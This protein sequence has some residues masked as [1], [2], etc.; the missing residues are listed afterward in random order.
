MGC[1]SLLLSLV[2]SALVHCSRHLPVPVETDR[3]STTP[4]AIE[5]T[6]CGQRPGC[7]LENSLR[8]GTASDGRDLILATVRLPALVARRCWPE[9]T[10]LLASAQGEVKRT[11]L[12]AEVCGAQGE[13]LPTLEP[14]GGNRV[15]YTRAV[16][17]RDDRDRIDPQEMRDVYDLAL[18]PPA[19]LRT[20]FR[21]QPTPYILYEEHWDHVGFRGETCVPNPTL[22]SGSCVLRALMLPVVVVQDIVHDGRRFG[23]DGWKDTDLGD[24]AMRIDGSP[25]GGFVTPAGNA[26]ASV[27]A[28]ASGT[29]VYLQITDDAFVTRGPVAD[30]IDID[31]PVERDTLTDLTEV[32]HLS[33]AGVLARRQGPTGRDAQSRVEVAAPDAH[34]R[35]FRLRD[36]LPP[37]SRK[38]R[39]A[40]IDVDPADGGQPVPQRLS[41]S[42]EG[43]RITATI[44]RIGPDDAVCVRRDNVLQVERRR[45]PLDPGE[46]MIPQ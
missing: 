18:D 19:I 33:M 3:Q 45:R 26:T 27:R 2:V 31:I 4:A 8:T 44:Q 16:E 13:A 9:E 22:D 42:E 23:D 28:V 10:W 37:D 6:A 11:Q 43:S 29:D 35:R 36:V 25:S 32:L 41:S 12:I 7:H 34:T 39:I 46:R 1:R 38:I 21:R 40:Y 30:E 15:R 14:L 20:T 17:I 24:C 5:S